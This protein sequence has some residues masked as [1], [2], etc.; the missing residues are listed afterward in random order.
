ME[1][2]GPKIQKSRSCKKIMTTVFGKSKGI[3]PHDTTRNGEHYTHLLK[4][5]HQSIKSKHRDNR[6][7][8][9]SCVTGQYS[10]NQQKMQWMLK[11]D[12]G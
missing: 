1:A 3:L 10:S 8:R 4:Q 7:R 9:E 2:N 6:T 12:V 5:R 11:N